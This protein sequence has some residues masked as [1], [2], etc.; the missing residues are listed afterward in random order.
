ML[1]TARCLKEEAPKPAVTYAQSDLHPPLPKKMHLPY[2]KKPQQ[3]QKTATR[4]KNMGENLRHPRNKRSLT[5]VKVG[6]LYMRLRAPRKRRK[7]KRETR[8]K[9]HAKQSDLLLH[10]WSSNSPHQECKASSAGVC[11]CIR[12]CVCVCAHFEGDGDHVVWGAG[13]VGAGPRILFALPNGHFVHCP[14]LPSPQPP[15]LSFP[16]SLSYSGGVH[17]ESRP[18]WR[19]KGLTC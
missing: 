19:M 2:T 8:G 14:P 11:A 16:L 15:P 1:W 6:R 12:E 5:K 4:H 13:G 3:K 9:R 7:Q 17:F 10:S 18:L